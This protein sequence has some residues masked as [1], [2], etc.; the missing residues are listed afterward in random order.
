MSHSHILRKDIKSISF[1]KYIRLSLVSLV[2]LQG[3]VFVTRHC[4]SSRRR[5]T[6]VTRRIPRLSEIFRNLDHLGV[7]RAR[8]ARYLREYRLAWS[9]LDGLDRIFGI[10][11]G[12]FDQISPYI[13]V[14]WVA[15][16]CNRLQPVATSCNHLQSVATSCNQL[17]PFATSCVEIR[18]LHVNLRGNCFLLF[19]F[20]QNSSFKT[21]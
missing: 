8:L 16:G 7:L 2:P 20:F 1:S 18:F 17:Q 15:T 11:A 19:N 13:N 6:R 10:V 14:S 4:H 3:N 9:V 5:V 12:H 21:P